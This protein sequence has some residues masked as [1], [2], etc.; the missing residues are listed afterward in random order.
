MYDALYDLPTDKESYCIAMDCLEMA[1]A[2]DL[3]VP[4]ININSEML[5]LLI[6]KYMSDTKN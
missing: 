4:Y 2:S 6:K 1:Y 5:K 3:I